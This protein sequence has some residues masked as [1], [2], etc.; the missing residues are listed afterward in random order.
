M[1]RQI[2]TAVLIAVA[3]TAATAGAVPGLILNVAHACNRP[4]CD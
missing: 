1:F 4:D 2:V 3:L